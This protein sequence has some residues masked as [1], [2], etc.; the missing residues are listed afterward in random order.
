MALSP[1]MEANQSLVDE[2]EW[3]PFPLTLD[4]VPMSFYKKLGMDNKTIATS[5]LKRDKFK[6]TRMLINASLRDS[7]N[8][9]YNRI[10]SI[11]FKDEVAD[12]KREIEEEKY[13]QLTLKR[14]RQTQ[15]G[16]GWKR[17]KL[18]SSAGI[19]ELCDE[20][21]NIEER[22]W[23]KL[24]DDEGKEAMKAYMME[25]PEI[26]AKFTHFMPVPA[27]EEDENSYSSGLG[28]K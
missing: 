3:C 24:E 9:I 22:I 1:K 27:D 7:S 6:A 20:Y 23:K 10:M 16:S 5:V 21:I 28:E 2:E 11:D 13:R 19:I 14:L 4:D 25:R 26:C 12:K 15:G 8:K 18:S 17:P